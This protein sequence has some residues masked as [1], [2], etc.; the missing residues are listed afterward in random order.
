MSEELFVYRANFDGAIKEFRIS[1]AMTGAKL[2]SV[3]ADTYG[4]SPNDILI[5][6]ETEGMQ[7]MPLIHPQKHASTTLNK[8]G[9]NKAFGRLSIEYRH[10]PGDEIVFQ[11]CL[12]ELSMVC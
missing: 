1:Y 4:V 3:V 5:Y 12:N 6:I 10:N 9:I 11:L 7:N 2:Y 8:V